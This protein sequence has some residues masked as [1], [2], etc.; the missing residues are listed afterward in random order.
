[1]MQFE[2][3]G[4]LW[5]L[6]AA[7]AGVIAL[8][9]LSWRRPQPH[10]LPTARFLP[11]APRRALSRRLQPSDAALLALRL[12]ALGAL[13]LAVAG[14]V[15][16]LRRPGLARVIAA[17]R[18][19]SVAS[20]DEVRDSVTVL[21][22]GASTTRVILFD[23]L[24]VPASDAAWRD[25]SGRA[26]RGSVD[27]A[28][29]TAIRE[30]TRLG[31]QF[32]SVEIVIV[33]PLH[34]EEVTA[35]TPRIRGVYG[36]AVRHVR[37]G[38]R[39]PSPHPALPSASWPPATD[40]LG[41]ALRLASGAPAA[42]LRVARAALTS[43]DSAH[44]TNG[45]VLLHWP[46]STAAPLETDGVLSRSGAVVG[47]FV[48]QESPD[49]RAIAWWS[50]GQ[51]AA[52]E[53]THGAGC[54]R[55]VRIGLPPAGDAVLRPAFQRLVRDLV[56]P[57][58][59]HDASVLTGEE[60]ATLFTRPTTSGVQAPAPATSPLTRRLLLLLALLALAAE[61][62]VR[63]RRSGAPDATGDAG[64]VAVAG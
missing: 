31:R 57:C 47:S 59:W 46:D 58:G 2:S 55:A 1:M 19:R 23:S 13:G 24:T 50:N 40:P 60:S 17:D 15:V 27:A 41:A 44:A 30:A 62:W 32:D 61:W 11:V 20:L 8:H 21:E 49:G 37:A 45:G 48:R 63:R 56:V 26:S 42:W 5:G 3:I 10:P 51:P 12:L 36:G 4:V 7:M 39:Q 16:Q 43:A 38:S 34:G 29:V 6:G 33:S 54:I 14:P 22:A 64:P 28:L 52:A 18:S 25:S 35:A 53:R 9:M